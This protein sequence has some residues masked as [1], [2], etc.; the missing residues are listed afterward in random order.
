VRAPLKAS[1]FV[2]VTAAM[3]GGLVL[4]VMRDHASEPYVVSQTA[5][6]GWTVVA[7]QP[8][9]PWL[10]AAHPPASLADSLFRQLS[11]KSQRPVVALPHPDLP[12]VLRA[13]YADA[14]QGVW[15][16]D[17]IVRAAQSGGIETASFEPVCM[18]HKVRTDE[19]GTSE[20]FFIVV[21]SPDFERL[22][23][24]LQPDFPEHAGIALYNPRAL[25]PLIPIAATDRAFDRWWPVSF[26]P[27]TDCQAQLT[28]Q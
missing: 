22:R 19:T 10:V 18:G 28:I 12:L 17:E 15:A 20:F 24:D 6:S 26:D 21:R 16:T 13:E 23:D 2:A 3:V 8:E 27:L 1:V 14:L 5:L 4:S 9:D 25:P 7:G 11:E